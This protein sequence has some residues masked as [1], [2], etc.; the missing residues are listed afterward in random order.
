MGAMEI[1]RTIAG[2]RRQVATR[3]GAGRTIGLAPTMGALHDGHLSLVAAARSA[4]D[5]VV[6]SIF[7]N[8]TQFGPNEDYT[9]YPRVEEDDLRKCREAGVDVAFVPPVEEIYPGGEATSVHVGKLTEHLCGPERPGHFDGVAT[10]VAKLLN[11]VQPDRAYFGEKDFQQLR[12]IQ[13]MVRDLDWPIEIVGCPIV[14][15]ADGLAASSRNAYLSADERGRALAVHQALAAG[16]EMIRAGDREPLAIT[17]EM[18]TI[19]EDAGPTRIDYISIVD[20]GDLQPV[21][22][23]DRRVLLAV[24]A[25]FG[26]TRLIDNLLVDPSTG[27]D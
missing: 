21:E 23:V 10:V 3:R 6:V 7:V 1:E 27:R 13:Q 12:V 2:V 26:R 4:C 22:R 9:K 24:A 20:P 18:R 14:R 15:E 11:I 19:L 25:R 5:V 16:R 8:P 17:R